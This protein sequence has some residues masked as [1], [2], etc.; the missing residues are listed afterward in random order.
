MRLVTLAMVLVAPLLTGCGD[1][2]FG[3]QDAIGL[4]D[5]REINGLTISG[6]TPTGVWIREVGG[7]SSLVVIGRLT[8][9]FAA[10]SACVW[11]VADGIHGEEMDDNCQYGIA[12]DGGISITVSDRAWAGAAEGTVMTLRDQAANALTLEKR[13]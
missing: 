6:T 10:A 4:W 13:M 2:P 1:D 9:E 5:A 8:V 7:D 12:S 3:V 11:T